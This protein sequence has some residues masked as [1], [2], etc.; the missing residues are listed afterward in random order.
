MYVKRNQ[1]ILIYSKL[2]LQQVY[3][4]S[5]FS[6]SNYSWVYIFRMIILQICYL[7]DCY[8]DYASCAHRIILIT[9]VTS[10]LTTPK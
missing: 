10:F 1:N 8:N 5:E 3:I 2:F 4:R 6:V 7:Q 9:V